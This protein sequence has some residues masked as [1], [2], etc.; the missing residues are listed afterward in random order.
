MTENVQL[1]EHALLWRVQQ[2]ES[3]RLGLGDLYANAH[4]IVE[5]DLC[6]KP[7]DRVRCVAWDASGR[8]SCHGEQGQDE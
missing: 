8:P 1:R 7:V 2:M 4:R 3:V 5:F 6:G